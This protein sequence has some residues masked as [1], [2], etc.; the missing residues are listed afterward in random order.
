VAVNSIIPLIAV[1]VLITLL[2]KG[3]RKEDYLLAD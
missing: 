3:R 1:I 2:L